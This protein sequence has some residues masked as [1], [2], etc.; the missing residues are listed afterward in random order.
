MLGNLLQSD[1]EEMIQNKE[2]AGLC[3]GLSEVDP[4]DIADLMIDFPPDDEGVIFRVLPRDRAAEAFAHLPPDH[5]EELGAS[6]SNEQ[7]QSI[8]AEITPD[9]RTRLLE[10][11]PA[12]VTRRLLEVLPPEQR[13]TANDLLDYPEESAGRFMTPA[14]VS[15]RPQ[16][17]VA[18]ALEHIRRS[19]RATETLNVVYVID[20]RGRLLQD[21]RLATLVRADPAAVVGA[22][23][24][25]PMV[26]V[27]ATTDREEVVRT[28][29]KYDRIALPV[30]DA[31]GHMLGIITVDD[32]M[33][34]AN[35]EV[36]EDFHKA[37]GMQALDEPYAAIGSFTL[38]KRRGGWLSALFIGEMFTATVMG[39][40]EGEIS[41]AVVLALFVPLITSSGGNSGSRA[42]TLVI[43]A[44]AMRELGL[45][46][47]WRVARREL[48]SG[49]ALG[50]W[51][52]AIG[53]MRVIL[54]QGTGWVSYGE[55][56]ALVALTVWASLIGVVTFGTMIGG[57]LPFTLR[58]VELDPAASSAP[59]VATLVDVTGWIIYFN[60]A[61]LIL[62]GTLL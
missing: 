54:W 50:G 48:A 61:F 42:S 60:V 23:E 32:L 55:H 11:L 25:R 9:D 37:G 15:L 27:L 20:E 12:A 36:T 47:W 6:L 39:H 58:R 52:G 22:V 51:L 26:S 38:L 5:Q 30:T 53:F 45:G 44:L 2:W 28:F 3:E 56:Y 41:Q 59:F 14:Y 4:S 57:M 13:K 19:P 10:E 43:R 31:A 8:I 18:E 33:D 62:R 16:L 1:L 29:E 21:L 24:D 40:C 46:D 35:E 49:L 17:M 7:V 34:V